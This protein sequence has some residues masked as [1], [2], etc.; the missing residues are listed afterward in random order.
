ML[1]GEKKICRRLNEIYNN[2][3][4]VIT[5]KSCKANGIVVANETS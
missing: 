3:T 1:S 5:L 2:I 4:V